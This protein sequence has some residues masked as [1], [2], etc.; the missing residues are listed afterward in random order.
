MLQAQQYWQ[1][2]FCEQ[3]NCLLL[4]MGDMQFATPY[5]RRQLT[6]E[7]LSNPN[8]NL[9]DADFYQQ[10]CQ[11][12][13]TFSLWTDAQICQ[14]ALNATAVKHYLKPMLAKS[15][16]FAPYAGGQVNQEAIVGLTSKAQRGQFLIVD[17]DQSA[18]VCLCLEPQFA[19]DDNLTLA[20]FEVIKVLNDRIEPLF[21]AQ[22][23]QKRA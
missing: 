1:W 21:C 10:V 19:L 6:D 2:L 18:S 5:K 22:G 9:Q 8:F 15:W 12:L 13:A 3:T 4:D 7:A 17:C 16:F 20:Q 11:Y 14:I 23:Q